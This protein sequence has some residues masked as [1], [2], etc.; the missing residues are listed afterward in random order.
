M[1]VHLR[2]YALV[3]EH[4]VDYLQILDAFSFVVLGIEPGPFT[5]AA[6]SSEIFLLLYFETG[7]Y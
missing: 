7:S 3:D 4:M 6:T 5:Q 2:K 1:N